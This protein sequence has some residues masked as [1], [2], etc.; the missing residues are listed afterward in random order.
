[1]KEFFRERFILKKGIRYPD[2]EVPGN[3]I[4]TMLTSEL[5]V[6]GLTSNL[7]NPLNPFV[8]G[9]FSVQHLWGLDVFQYSISGV[10]TFF[11]GGNA[12]RGCFFFNS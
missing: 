11:N 9:R 3:K 1:M 4:S 2:E 10:W 12:R 6:T 5:T 7:N 8:S